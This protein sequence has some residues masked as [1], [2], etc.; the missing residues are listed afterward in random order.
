MEP[1]SALIATLAVV[2]ALALT[3]LGVRRALR[4]RRVGDPLGGFLRHFE[5]RGVP[6]EIAHAAYEELRSWLGA[7]PG[8][9][10]VRP[11]DDLQHVYGVT[12]DERREAVE[13]VARACG[14]TLP[15]DAALADE[16]GSVED[17][18]DAVARC[19]ERRAP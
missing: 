3:L 2:A 16:V 10:R 8:A 11:G 14:R 4:E 15:A 12:P 6:P 13:L 7:A 5:R 9:H 1:W 17:L 19:P 18:V